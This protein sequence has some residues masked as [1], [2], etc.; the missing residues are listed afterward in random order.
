MSLISELIAGHPVTGVY[1]ANATLA[2]SQINAENVLVP[3]DTMT[4][5]EIL[6]S[7]NAGE[8]A[9]LTN[10]QQ[11]LVWDIVHL[12]TINPFGVEATLITGVFPDGGLTL[13]ALAAAR[14]E[15]VSQATKLGLGR[16]TAGE[17][18]RARA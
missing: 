1:N 2:A 16:P 8:W 5:S 3:K 17:I 4:G 10:A 14:Q 6:Q 15:L 13:V 7:I 9:A 11:Q 12:G 18:E